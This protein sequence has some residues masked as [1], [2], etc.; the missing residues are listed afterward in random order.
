MPKAMLLAFNVSVGFMALSCS[1]S[2]ADVPLAVAVK[3][4]VWVVVTEATVAVKAAVV[5]PGGTVTDPGTVTALSLLRRLIGRPPVP[6]AEFRVTEQASVPEPVKEPVAQLSPLSTPGV[7]RPVPLR[8]MVAV[9]GDA[10]SLKVMIP[11]AVPVTVG[12]KVTVRAAV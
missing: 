2:V 6:A 8:L 1:A 7:A 3:V 5:A 11:L 10:L 4:A 12:A 9:P